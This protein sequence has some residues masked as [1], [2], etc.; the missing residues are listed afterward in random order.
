[1]TINLSGTGAQSQI[2][3]ITVT[4]ANQTVPSGTQ[5]Q[6]KAVDNF[7]NDITSS[8]AWSSSD[9]SIVSIT[10]GG[11][12]TGIVTGTAKIMANK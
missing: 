10:A 2:T 8:V 1:L 9:P 7:G 11:L 6:F 5:V 12:A 3:S 4:P